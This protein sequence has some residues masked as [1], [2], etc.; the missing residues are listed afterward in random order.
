MPYVIAEPFIHV[1]DKAC[2]EVCP[3]DCIYERSSGDSSTTGRAQGTA[4]FGSRR[5][6]K[7]EHM[8]AAFPF[9]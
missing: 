6:G 8:A 7:R 2:V 5:E 3:V 9:R 4:L 1:T